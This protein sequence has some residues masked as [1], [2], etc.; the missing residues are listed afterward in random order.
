LD[1][2]RANLEVV[3]ARGP[4]VSGGCP[5]V[6]ELVPDHGPRTGGYEVV[7]VGH[8]LPDELTL[9]WSVGDNVNVTAVRGR[10]GQLRMIVPPAGDETSSGALVR[11]VDAPRIDASVSTFFVWDGK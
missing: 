8:N 1:A 3:S 11:I 9:S 10:D 5:E 7:V 6:T 2:Y 4:T